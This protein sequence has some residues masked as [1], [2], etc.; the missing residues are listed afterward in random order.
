MY[1]IYGIALLRHTLNKIIRKFL[2]DDSGRAVTM[3]IRD[4]G[5]GRSWAPALR[6]QGYELQ[7]YIWPG[8]LPT[9]FEDD[10]EPV[11]TFVVDAC[12]CQPFT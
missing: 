7:P 8:I 6:Q 10:I 12:L 3:L 5:D 4:F 2:F 9:V 11:R 1:L